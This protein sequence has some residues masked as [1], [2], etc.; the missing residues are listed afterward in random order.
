VAEGIRTRLIAAVLLVAIALDSYG[1][2]YYAFQGFALR[3]FPH[4]ELGFRLP[5]LFWA[6]LSCALIFIVAARW[7][8]LWFATALALFVNGSQTFIYLSQLV[9]DQP[10]RSRLADAVVR[11]KAK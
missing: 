5:S 11:T 10:S 6:I 4:N 7:R 8:G 9:G 3:F 2:I 1:P